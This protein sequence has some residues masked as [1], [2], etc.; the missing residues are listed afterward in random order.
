MKREL[1]EQAARIKQL[2]G[3]LKQ[4]EKS[5]LTGAISADVSDEIDFPLTHGIQSMQGGLYVF[6]LFV[7]SQQEA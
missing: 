1:A 7:V 3:D 2:E 6:L 4:A 5:G